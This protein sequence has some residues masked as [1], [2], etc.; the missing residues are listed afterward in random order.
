MS[1]LRLKISKNDFA[2]FI[3]QKP[4]IR[5]Q[6]LETGAQRVVAN[7]QRRMIEGKGVA[8][9][10]NLKTHQPL[11]SNYKIRPSGRPAKPPPLIDT[12]I[13]M[14]SFGIDHSQSTDNKVVMNVAATIHSGSGIDSRRLAGFHQFGTKRMPARPHIGFSKKDKA[15][16]SKVFH[17][18]M[19][20]QL[21]KTFK[22]HRGN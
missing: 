19:N 2:R 20:K 6:I 21:L 7:Y 22:K 10:G 14:S 15:D 18:M 11:S 9:A 12:N 16:V 5:R 17:L 3:I 1:T 8:E 4:E 13:M